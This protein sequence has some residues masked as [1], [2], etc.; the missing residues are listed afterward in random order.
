MTDGL[1]DRVVLIAGATGALGSA[2][3]REFAQTGAHLAL[4]SRSMEALQELMAQIDLPEER[5]VSIRADVTQVQRVHA[6]VRDVVG[7]FGRLDVLLNTVGGWSGGASVG[8]T[9]VDDWDRM[10]NLNLRS[11]FL[12]SRAVLP[13]MLK[14][15]WGRILHVSSKTAVQP[16]P[17]QVG[18]VVSKKGLIAL[19]EAIAAEVKGTGVTANVILPSII[20]TPANRASMPKASPQKW[21]SPEQI[22][23]MMRCLCSG[24]GAA[25]HGASIPMYG[26]I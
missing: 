26:A 21:V 25:L 12:L 14:A 20:D 4:T 10:L 23:V 13:H 8:E 2:V 7:R 1:Q 6:L 22:A 16:R 3:S 24:A 15:G 18:Y 11:A 5:I 19:T 17:K 9:P